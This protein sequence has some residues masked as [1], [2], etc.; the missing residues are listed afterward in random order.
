MHS[1]MVKQ[2]LKDG[3]LTK[4]QYD[5]LPDALLE[6]IVKSKK[7]NGVK[8]KTGGA[9]KS[10]AKGSTRKAKPSGPK[11]ATNVPKGSHRMPDGSIM[12]DSK[13]KKKKGKK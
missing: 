3:L 7:K 4:K 13:M 9:G 1:E 11:N 12:K 5:K 6:G 10:R 8:G 2:A